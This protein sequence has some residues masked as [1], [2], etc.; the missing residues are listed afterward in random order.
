[1]TLDEKKADSHRLCLMGVDE[2]NVICVWVAI[3]NKHGD[4]EGEI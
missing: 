1:M 2:G 4:R 3:N